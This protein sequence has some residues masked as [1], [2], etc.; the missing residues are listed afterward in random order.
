MNEKR[1]TFCNSSRRLIL[2]FLVLVLSCTYVSVS[3]ASSWTSELDQSMYERAY[4]DQQQEEVTKELEGLED[5]YSGV[6][7]DVLSSLFAKFFISV[8]DAIYKILAPMGFELNSIIY[9]RVGGSAYRTDNISIF[10]YELTNGNVYG[11]VSMVLFGLLRGIV[12]VIM[13]CVVLY[14]MVAFLWTSGSAKARENVKSSIQIF[15]IMFL[16]LIL[17][18]KFL[19]LVLYIR[20]LI[21]FAEMQYG[22][23]LVDMVGT[24]VNPD[25]SAVSDT[26]N[27]AFDFFG[28]GGNYNLIGMF[29][30]IA[31]NDKSFI[32]AALYLGSVVLQF[33]FG[34]AYI[35]AAF[36]LLVLV[37]L[38]PFCVVVEMF[39]RTTIKQWIRQVTGILLNPILDSCLML[40]PMIFMLHG[41]N[42]EHGGYA[43]VSLICCS[44]IIPARGVIR[45]VLQLGNGLGFEMAGFGAVMGAMRLAGSVGKAVGNLVSRT[46]SGMS[47]AKQDDD[48]S[49]MYDEQ[50]RRMD[51]DSFNEQEALQ[52]DIQ[53]IFGTDGPQIDSDEVGFMPLDEGGMNELTPEQKALAR[54]E[55]IENGLKELG[56]RKEQISDD[57]RNGEIQSNK[58]G[59][60]MDEID[61]HTAE[62]RAQRAGL[63][64]EDMHYKENVRELDSQIAENNIDRQHLAS[65]RDKIRTVNSERKDQIGK[66]ESI[67][68]RSRSAQSNMRAAG[69]VGSYRGGSQSGQEILDRYA[70]VDNFELPEFRNISMERKAELYRA[71]A[72]QTR[73]RTVA[74][75]GGGV[76]GNVAL[77]SV[78]LA[79]SAYASPMTK[80]YMTSLG[81]E[82]GGAIGAVTGD[83]IGA[84]ASRVNIEIPSLHRAQHSPHQTEV[85]V[86]PR[87]PVQP[88][89]IEQ[90][91]GYVGKSDY[92][93]DSNRHNTDYAR[94]PTNYEPN[95]TRPRKEHYERQLKAAEEKQKRESQY[96]AL[97]ESLVFNPMERTSIAGEMKRSMREASVTARQSFHAT[98]ERGVDTEEQRKELNYQI[99]D[100]ALEIYSRSMADKVKVPDKETVGEEFDF[101][102][103]DMY[104][105]ERF[106]RTSR[107]QM[108]RYLCSKGIL[109]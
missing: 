43:L 37:L 50:S 49:D 26:G 98:K 9:G 68:R 82:A 44:C 72:K 101:E 92:Y 52:N 55:N 89:Q 77:G 24:K 6:A 12:S 66:I 90:K 67:E 85:P 91:P 33:Y 108:E 87:Q 35:S 38:F 48:L 51:L 103:F 16:S 63:D 109:F 39:D 80:A 42:V 79:G 64:P 84:R 61:Q 99:V 102:E 27:A 15:A 17:F 4:S 78:A 57:I 28:I 76:A 74:S 83:Y 100:E 106:Q 81:G 105:E 59:E 5:R 56:V 62:L 88:I 1:L 7:G 58:I 53:T 73:M 31:D 21:L 36:A 94:Q 3:F 96:D 69:S 32:N 13:I 104:V 34:A 107:N 41:Y 23:E 25:W 75:V 18:P 54:H 70:N 8:G 47:A 20:D 14:R 45:S 65:A 46:A 2:L 29:R 11:L 60:Q 19:D 40:V 10:T 22:S 71:R 93:S 86:I 97:Y 95:W 30:T